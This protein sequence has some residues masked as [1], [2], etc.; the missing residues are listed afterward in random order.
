KYYPS[1]ASELFR[2][3]IRIA[4]NSDKKEWIATFLKPWARV[5][6]LKCMNKTNLQKSLINPQQSIS[7]NINLQQ[8]NTIHKLDNNEATIEGIE[9]YVFSIF[10]YFYILYLHLENF[11]NK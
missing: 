4:E 7:N 1:I 3:A 11:F 2:F 8:S 10:I 9:S 5:L 6:K